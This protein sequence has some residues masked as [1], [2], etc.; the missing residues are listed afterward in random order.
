MA[1]VTHLYDAALFKREPLQVI[2]ESISAR[3]RW[4][5]LAWHVKSKEFAKKL[6][7]ERGINMLS[8]P[9]SDEQA[10]A[11]V[12]SRGIHDRWHTSRFRVDVRVREWL[13]ERK[14]FF[15]DQMQ[16]PLEGF[17]LMAATRHA[18]EQLPYA[19]AERMP[20]SKRVHYPK[21]K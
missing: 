16:T 17:P 12:I 15:R 9:S 1:D 7:D 18:L 3:G 4:I 20:G 14:T 2:G 5:P 13:D 6:L 8:E 21:I 11:E 19:R 10:V